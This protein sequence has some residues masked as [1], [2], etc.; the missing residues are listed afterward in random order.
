VRF[1]AN[2]FGDGKT[3]YLGTLENGPRTNSILNETTE[4]TLLFKKGIS[5]PEAQAVASYLNER[6][7]KVGLRFKVK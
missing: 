2:E 3:F 7:E 5:F 6:L 1:K 4:L